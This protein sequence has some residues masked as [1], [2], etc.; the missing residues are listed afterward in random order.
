MNEKDTLRLFDL[1]LAREIILMDRDELFRFV[2][3]REEQLRGMPGKHSMFVFSNDRPAARTTAL[4]FNEFFNEDPAQIRQMLIH[5]LCYPNEPFEINYYARC[6]YLDDP[7][8]VYVSSTRE[9]TNGGAD[10]VFET[11]GVPAVAESCFDMV[12]NGGTVVLVGIPAQQATISI[13]PADLIPREI[14]ILTSHVGSLTPSVDLPRYIA[15]AKQG[16]LQLEPMVSKRFSLDE[17]NEGFAMMSSGT[18]ARS[19]VVF[20]S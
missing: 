19:I 16:K 7:S 1:G 3:S 18:T 14:A 11:S 15:L 5:D 8:S 2:E 4:V 20:D 17:I 12:G 6:G 13:R 10:Y 9:L